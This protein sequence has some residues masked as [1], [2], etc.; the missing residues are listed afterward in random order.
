MSPGKK[1]IAKFPWRI[2]QNRLANGVS[3]DNT[4]IFIHMYVRVHLR[5]H[6]RIPTKAI[7]TPTT[8]RQRDGTFLKVRA[9][10]RTLMHVCTRTYA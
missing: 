3:R 5:E 7:P 1:K 10:S 6:I 9:R 2:S 8:G 4:R